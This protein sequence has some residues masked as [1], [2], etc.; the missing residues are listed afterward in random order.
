[1][2]YRR[3]GSWVSIGALSLLGAGA[4]VL[5]VAAGPVTRPL[6]ARTAGTVTA[7]T[8]GGTDPTTTSSAPVTAATSTTAPGP[9]PAT[10]AAD[11]VSAPAFGLPTVPV[12]GSVAGLSC[13]S[14]S[15]CMAAGSLEGGPGGTEA[16]LE[17]WDGSSWSALPSPVVGD[18]TWN[19]LNGVS[20]PSASFC[21]AV[22]SAESG[23]GAL[24]ETW[25][26]TRWTV[27]QS[28]AV[29]TSVLRAVSCPSASFCAAVGDT[30]GGP[31]GTEAVT[32]L[33]DG[34]AWSA[35]PTP[36]VAGGRWNSLSALTCTSP[37]AC[38]ATGTYQ[39]DQGDAPL[40]ESWD[41]RSWS[42]VSPP[43]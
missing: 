9:A 16:L 37:A 11:G 23:I 18:G 36:P 3:W 4:V 22:G 34:S 5:S 28:P 31:G 24:V 40:A 41:G 27:A 19:A 6:E 12:G 10:A 42:V 13:A 7:A 29:G 32:E 38:A 43:G 15:F 14:A 26:G 30:E 21:V 25:D 2:G 20:C 39:S 1:M 8:A 17:A 35:P 33:W